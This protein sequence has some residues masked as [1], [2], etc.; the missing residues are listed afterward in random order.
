MDDDIYIRPL[1]LRYLLTRLNLSSLVSTSPLIS[2]SRGTGQS[3]MGSISPLI[4]SSHSVGQRAMGS[5]SPLIS[6]HGVGQRA[7]GSIIRNNNAQVPKITDEI[8][9]VAA[10]KYRN[11]Q[12]SNR[13]NRTIHPCDV[14]GVFD[15]PLAQPVFLNR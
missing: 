15:F 6:S 5:T 12:Y 13:W 8:A 2:S 14:P 9:L 3:V 7:M 4:S 10:S 1:T 11:L